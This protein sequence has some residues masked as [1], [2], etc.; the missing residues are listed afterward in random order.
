MAAWLDTARDGSGWHLTDTGRLQS[1]TRWMS[2]PDTQYPSLVCFA[3]NG[4]RV[5]ALRALFPHNNV[6]RRGPAALMRLHLST[7]TAGTDHP[8][9]VTEC[10]SLSSSGFADPALY[11][12][13]P[14]S[15][16]QYLVSQRVDCPAAEVNLRVMSKVVLPWTQILC[17]F[18]DSVS[19]MRDVQRLLDQA[20]HQIHVGSHPVAVSFRVLVILTS[21][22]KHASHE[23]AAPISQE[24]FGDA[25]APEI[26]YVDLRHRSELSPAAAF[27]PLRSAI[28]DRLL[29]VRDEQAQCGVLFSANH[30]GALWKANLESAMRSPDGAAFDCLRVARS[31]FPPSSRR[32]ACL[33]DFLRQ[34]NEARCEGKDVHSFIAS[35]LLMDAYPPGMHCEPADS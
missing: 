26:T 32:V 34:T 4:N 10:G 13:A 7:G 21:P 33:V 17:L 22:P 11:R 12:N 29:S 5:R 6:T 35:A 3:G 30:L 31:G 25:D 19:E 18:V 14:Q 16:R 9:L 8:V 15:F 20:R 27:E 23:Q 2:H 1:L 28:L 24:D